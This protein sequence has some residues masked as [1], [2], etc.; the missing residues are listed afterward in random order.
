MKTE[1]KRALKD[2]KNRVL[3][4]NIGG[5]VLIKGLS[6][7]IS[8]FATPAYIAYFCDNAV[9]GV[10]YTLVAALNWILTFDFGVGNGLRNNLA[11]ALASKDFVRAKQLVSTAYMAVGGLTVI[12]I[13]FGSIVILPGDW[14]TILN[15]GE[16]ALHSDALR[17]SVLI[18]FIGTMLQFFLK[19]L[20]SVLFSLQK[21]AL[22]NTLFLTGNVVLLLFLVLCR[23]DTADEALIGLSIAQVIAVNLPLLAGSIWFFLG[24]GRDFAPS[25]QYWTKSAIKDVLGLGSIFFVVQIAFLFINSTNEYL[26]TILYGTAPVVD[27][28]V[29]Y[30]CF[31]LISTIFMLAVQPIWSAMTVAITEN[32]KSWVIKV[33]KLFCVGAA[34]ATA[35]ALVLAS[36]FP[37]IVSIWLGKDAIDT[38]YMLSVIFALLVS[39]I[40]FVNCS[41]CI[42]NASNR[43]K[44]QLV[45]SAVGAF[46]KVLLAIVFAALG[47]PWYSVVLAN[48]LAL[49]PLLIA[50]VR[51]NNR[52]L[53]SSWEC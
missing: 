19:L 40:L 49:M 37:Y 12:G 8:L 20:T 24:Q 53:K 22:N 35:F 29:Y 52:Y 42:A 31:F 27:Y 41:T 50:Q 33:Y 1:I 2:S 23:P 30:K 25:L 21:T 16:S 7:V 28:Q 32:R 46:A 5:T 39:I 18:V 14:A 17:F 3:L 51:D 45:F 11:V 48:A 9:L 44:T 26:I 15:Y 38:P 13:A 36:L 34:I 10:W 4:G 47:F 43:L 6:V